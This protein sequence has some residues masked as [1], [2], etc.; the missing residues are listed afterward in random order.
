MYILKNIKYFFYKKERNFLFFLKNTIGFYPK[1]LSIYK[2]AFLHKSASAKNNERLEFLGDAILSSVV[3]NFLY[4]KFPY[5]KEG[6]LTKIRSRIVSRN[7]LNFVAKKLNLSKFMIFLNV[8]DSK[9]IYGN[10]L[11]AL[12]GAIFIDKGYEKTKKFIIRRIIDKYIDL[13][14]IQKKDINFK[15]QLLEL[16]QKNKKEMFFE[17]KLYIF[18]KNKF[19]S[20]VF[21]NNEELGIGF[22]SSKKEA[23][24]KASKESLK[25]YS[26]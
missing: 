19:I 25:I 16:T 20:K 8:K 21:V 3:A 6:F 9:N 15:S 14:E 24:Q 12:I 13:N 26:K 1:K 23:E 18:E 17:T 7:N 5:K 10:T 22:G 4:E 11:E 2:L